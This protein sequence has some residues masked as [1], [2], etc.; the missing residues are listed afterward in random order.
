MIQPPPTRGITKIHHSIGNPNTDLAGLAGLRNSTKLDAGA[1]GAAV[2]RV[3]SAMRLLLL[4]A[5]LCRG[6]TS[7]AKVTSA[8]IKGR[9]GADPRLDIVSGAA[10]VPGANAW[11]SY[12]ATYSAIGWDVLNVTTSPTGT[13]AKGDD[14]FAAGYLEGYLTQKA[15]YT[16]YQNSALIQHLGGS[17]WAGR[18]V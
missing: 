4:A 14:M 15:I 9:D 10:P 16:S 18:S 17:L 12:A 6:G 1:A 3:V 5:L 8:I 7:A 11:A 13:G 2:A